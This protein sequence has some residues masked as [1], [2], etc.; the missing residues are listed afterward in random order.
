LISFTN[1]K[2]KVLKLNEIFYDMKEVISD[3][4]LFPSREEL[5]YLK[6]SAEKALIAL[7]KEI[8]KQKID[9]DV[10]IGGSFAKGT[11]MKGKD[12]DI[13][14]FVRFSQKH[15]NISGLLERIMKEVGK[16]V[17]KKLNKVHG[18]RDYFQILWDKKTTFEIIPVNKI[19]KPSE[20][21][22]VTDLSYFHVGYVKKRFKDERLQR[23]LFLAKK[24]CKANGFYGAESYIGGFSGYAL[25][26]LI[27]YYKSFE[28][29]LKELIKIDKE[30]LVIDSEKQC[31]T[32]RSVFIELNESKTQGPIILIDPT[33]KERNAL[34]ALSWDTLRRFQ[35]ITKE[36]LKTKSTRYFE[37][38]EKTDFSG[39]KSAEIVKIKLETDRQKGDIAGTK[40]KKFYLL[41]KSRLERY[42]D[43]VG[44]EFGYGLGQEALAVYALRKKK[45]VIKEGPPI[46]MRK[47]LGLFVKKNKNVFYKNGKAYAKEKMGFSG[48]MFANAWKLKNKGLM[49][50]MSI[51]GMKVV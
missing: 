9:A 35:K 45:E 2:R 34:A 33:W 46:S 8:K 4:E 20:E 48:R 43:V 29:M 47:E 11:I 10:F 19:K 28:R 22:N 1:P 5:K 50:D 7:K 17:N 32:K 30:A 3:K 21:K 24:F 25:E 41:F 12:Y 36:Y 6:E 27:L 44:E 31:K 26:C 39:I 38:R 15:E 42:F 51:S 14:I 40:L 13:D 16:K 23:E 37:M 18:S 49:N